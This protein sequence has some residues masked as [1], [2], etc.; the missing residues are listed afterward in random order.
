M[1]NI[2]VCRGHTLI[3]SFILVPKFWNVLLI[4]ITADVFFLSKR[5]SSLA[6]VQNSKFWYLNTN[7]L[8]E[9][10][11]TKIFLVSKTLVEVGKYTC[12]LLLLWNM[13]EN[14]NTKSN[15]NQATKASVYHLDFRWHSLVASA[16]LNSKQI[17]KHLL[18]KLF[19]EKNSRFKNFRQEIS[20][21][22]EMVLK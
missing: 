18:R 17:S 15:A 20:K 5:K 9:P 2:Y 6:L 10:L 7:I 22:T 12:I 1:R 16:L 13:F 3:F 4:L 19:G 21:S 8:I 14:S 11:L